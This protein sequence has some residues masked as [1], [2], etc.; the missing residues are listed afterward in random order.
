MLGPNYVG[1]KLPLF[2]HAAV[3][4]RSQ[5][6]RLALRTSARTVQVIAFPAILPSAAGEVSRTSIQD[7]S[8]PWSLRRC[9]GSSRP[10][11][12][13]HGNVKSGAE[14]VGSLTEGGAAS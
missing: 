3:Y 8:K 1:G 5:A 7:G 4:I 9:S 11:R 6:S 12:E 13:E 14:T 2:L 10:E